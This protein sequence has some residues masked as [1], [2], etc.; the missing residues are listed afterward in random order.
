MNPI[1]PVDGSC[2]VLTA[3]TALSTADDLVVGSPMASVING[4]GAREAGYVFVYAGGSSFPTGD[5]DNAEAAAKWS[6]E[7]LSKSQRLGASFAV[8]KSPTGTTVLLAGAPRARLAR[9]DSDQGMDMAGALYL[10]TVS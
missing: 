5:V 6:Y 8:A 3:S 2:V 9:G 10:L 4:L 1:S 7:G